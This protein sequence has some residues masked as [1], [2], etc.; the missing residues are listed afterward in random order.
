MLYHNEKSSDEQGLCTSVLYTYVY[1]LGPAGRS[2]FISGELKD[3]WDSICL[4]L[5]GA[6][7]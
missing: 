3:G 7:L 5:T 4:W 1:N 6:L 2:S